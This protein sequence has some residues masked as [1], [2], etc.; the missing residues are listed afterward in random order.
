MIA[1]IDQYFH[2]SGTV[3]SLGYIFQLIH[4]KQGANEPVITLKARFSCLFALL[5]IRGVNIDPPPQVCFMLRSL[6]YTYH[7]VVKDFQLGRHSLMTAL[8]QTV[9]DQYTS[10]DKDPWKG[11]VC[12]V[13]KCSGPINTLPRQQHSS[14]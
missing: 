5:K 14:F 3:D 10:Y 1:H 2:P 8:L 6:L 4:I 13:S 11:S 9:V 12:M 7:G